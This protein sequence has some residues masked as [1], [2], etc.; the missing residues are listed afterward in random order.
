MA[1]FG[2]VCEKCLEADPSRIELFTNKCFQ[3]NLHAGGPIVKVVKTSSRRLERL[4]SD[5]SVGTR[6]QPIRPMP[7]VWFRGEFVLCN[8]K[9]CKEERC[10]YPHSVEERDAWNAEKF[11]CKYGCASPPTAVEYKLNLITNAF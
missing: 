11:G 3:G 7:R 4:R 2:L 9:H 1:E 5:T 6:T 8:G 10:T